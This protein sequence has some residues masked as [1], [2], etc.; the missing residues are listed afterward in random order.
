MP[1]NLCHILLERP[2]QY[3]GKVVHDRKTNCYKFFKD[4]IMHTLVTIKEEETIETSGTR[5]LLM[6]GK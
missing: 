2:W 5:V 6:G 1:M 3:D 4:G